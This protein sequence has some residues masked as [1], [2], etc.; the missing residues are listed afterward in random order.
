MSRNTIILSMCNR[1]NRLDTSH[2]GM[3]RT[4]AV[5]TADWAGNAA[6][7]AVEAHSGK[8]AP[9]LSRANNHTVAE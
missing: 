4:F 9:R 5:T 2:Y 3:L 6:I 7:E 8:V 1:H